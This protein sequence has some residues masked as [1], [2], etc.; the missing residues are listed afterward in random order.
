MI[1][2]NRA[3]MEDDGR[4]FFSRFYVGEIVQAFPG[5]CLDVIAIKLV[6]RI[7]RP[8]L[9]WV[10]I[11][12]VS[13]Q[14]VD[15]AVTVGNVRT[16]RLGHRRMGQKGP[17]ICAR[18]VAPQVV[19]R[20]AI[21]TADNS[22]DVA[23]IVRQCPTCAD[24]LTRGQGHIGRCS[25]TPRVRGRIV[26]PE[27]VGAAAPHAKDVPIGHSNVTARMDI[28]GSIGHDLPCPCLEIVS[29]EVGRVLA[30]KGIYVTGVVQ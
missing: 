30:A 27:R 24:F 5:I 10:V 15:V 12:V 7:F 16:A 11:A 14:E 28:A 3:R 9:G 20:A 13:T 21:V 25:I 26:S 8:P 23:V 6:S 17:R 19:I 18:V 4:P 29:P 2:Q 22:V 1:S